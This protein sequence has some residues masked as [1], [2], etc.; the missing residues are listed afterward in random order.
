MKTRMERAGG[1]LSVVVED[2]GEEL[3]RVGI[4]DTYA[5]WFLDH[6]SLPKSTPA[7]VKLGEAVEAAKGF[8]LRDAKA[9]AK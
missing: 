2:G 4:Y 9:Q 8:A 7:F 5:G 3:S 6:P 1:V